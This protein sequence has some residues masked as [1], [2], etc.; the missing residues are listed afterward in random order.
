LAD[1]ARRQR[2]AE[3]GA[4]WVR[5]ERT[6]AAN[7]DT[8]LRLYEQL[9]AVPFGDLRMANLSA[10]RI[11]VAG[12]HREFE[13]REAIPLELLYETD[14]QGDPE[15]YLS[16]GW[17]HGDQ[18]RL[19]L[20]PP[21]E[22]TTLYM[23][24]RSANF[25]VHAW[26]FMGS[27]LR[28]YEATGESRYLDWC[29]ERAV[30]WAETFNEGDARG[31]MA[32]YDM[33][34]GLRAYRLAY[35][36]EQC[37]LRGYPKDVLAALLTCVVRHQRE[38]Y[39]DRIFNP[40][41][42]HGVYLSLGQLAFARR[43]A[44]LA[45]MDVMERQGRDRLAVVTK[46]QF[47]AD[48]GHLEHSPAYH[49]MLLNSFRGG[50]TA[51]LFDDPQLRERI[52]SAEDVLGWFIQPN[53][54][55][56][57]L[58][59]SRAIKMRSSKPITA[60]PFTEFHMSRGRSGTPTAESLR[61]MPDSGYA[62]VRHPQPVGVADHDRAGYLLMA[63][64]FHSRTHKHADDLLLTWCDHGHELLIDA[65]RF[66]YV[67]LL[68][69]DSPL[70]QKGFFYSAPERQYIESTRAHNT[71]EADGTDHLRRGREPYGSGIQAAEERDGVFRLLGSVDHVT[72][73]HRREVVFRPGEW[74]QVIDTVSALD[75]ESHDYRVW[76]NMPEEVTPEVQEDGGLG[77]SVPTADRRLWLREHSG[78]TLIEPVKGQQEPL[79]G[80]RSKVDLRFTPAWSV[81][82][83]VL[84]VSDHEF[85]TVFC[86]ADTLDAGVQDNPF[87]PSSGA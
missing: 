48:G 84:G 21:I 5:T 56:V 41:N 10:E 59:D 80:W 40:R 16:E 11:S 47:A 30:S 12:L 6:W 18:P 76:W 69:A 85:R 9:G 62:I 38:F 23:E 7:A 82:F 83:E 28:A 25:S 52:A 46:T 81:G 78:S 15:V 49:R 3:A 31:T 4:A 44:P 17:S 50:I 68:P 64:A 63:A 45:G 54:E 22:W 34:I 72:W 73:K 70:R 86:F 32:W 61:V 79:R 39:D 14:T 26:D 8:Y 33:A 77:I 51:G 43:L 36:V 87:A 19:T 1:P 2:L 35:L 58:G 27:V 57:Q 42:N 65:G 37:V 66:G 67:D 71:V 55:L 20:A 74:L 29:V 24:N 13:S 75:G 60:S 53:G